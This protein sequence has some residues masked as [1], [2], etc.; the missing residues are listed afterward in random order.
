[1]SVERLKGQRQ[2]EADKVEAVWETSI[3]HGDAAADNDWV[4]GGQC[5]DSRRSEL[6]VIHSSVPVA[7]KLEEGQGSHP[8]FSRILK[9][10]LPSALIFVSIDASATA[11]FA[12]K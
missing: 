2:I 3:E 4:A 7:V 8:P 5:V 9:R 12:Q 10:L 11:I 1:M 6:P